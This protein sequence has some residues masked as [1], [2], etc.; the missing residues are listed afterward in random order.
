MTA[1]GVGSLLICQR[2][3]AKAR[4][5]V[6]SV[7]PL[8]VPLGGEEKTR[9]ALA[10]SVSSATID[11]A[12]KRGLAW[13]GSNFTMA[14]D[15]VIG[16]SSFYARYGIERIG[17]PGRPQHP[18]PDRLVRGGSCLHLQ[19]SA[20]GRKLG[21]GVRCQDEHRLSDPVPHALDGQDSAAD[22]GQAARRGDAA[23]GRGLPNDL[24]SLTVAGGRIVSRPMS[25]A[26]EGMPAVLV[27]PRTQ[28]TDAALAGL[29]ARYQAEG[30]DVLRPHKDRVRKLLADRDPGLRRVAA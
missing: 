7:H 28:N 16:P 10:G 4:Q 27:D 1:A 30:P 6:D 23:G 9:R 17:G 2:Q 3:L 18:R 15:L 12:V 24:P 14:S 26:V 13:Q 19:E 5:R 29:M 25:G 20:A 11:Q 8:L 22:R 21:L